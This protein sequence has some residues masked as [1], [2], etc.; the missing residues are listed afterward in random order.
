MGTISLVELSL[1]GSKASYER[2]TGR[3]SIDR[4]Y[5]VVGVGPEEAV[6]IRYGALASKLIPET[7]TLTDVGSGNPVYAFAKDRSADS[8]IGSDGSES[9][10]QVTYEGYLWAPLYWEADIVTASEQVI[11]SLPDASG[12]S[13]QIGTNAEGTQAKRPHLQ[14][15][16]F[17]NVSETELIEGGIW[18]PSSSGGSSSVVGSSE[19]SGSSSPLPSPSSSSV[20]SSGSTA[21]SSGSSSSGW[22][23]LF[24]S[25]GNLSK[26]ELIRFLSGKVCENGWTPSVMEGQFVFPLGYWLYDGAKVT[27]LGCSTMQ[28]QHVFVS[29]P[30]V[31]AT[32]TPLMHLYEWRPYRTKSESVQFTNEDSS[33][34]TLEQ[35]RRI[36]G[37]PVSSKIQNIAGTDIP[38]LFSDLG[39]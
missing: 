25:V 28:L 3:Y 9:A 8:P 37:E 38:Y 15:T 39:L 2:K 26:W 23:S 11:A 31:D 20:P 35:E 32:K 13:T 18:T 29:V 24:P 4:V 34:D 12:Q 33:V 19:S 14:L 17:E 22:G 10:L 16:I 30:P 36:Y 5:R 6:C 27:D 7:L 21:G 1:K